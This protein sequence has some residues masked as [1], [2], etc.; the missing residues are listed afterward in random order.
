[1]L[2]GGMGR[3][4]RPETGKVARQGKARHLGATSSISAEGS[5]FDSLIDGLAV[6]L[7][8]VGNVQVDKSRSVSLGVFPGNT[9]KDWIFPRNTGLR[10]G[11]AGNMLKSEIDGQGNGSATL[12]DE[13]PI[14]NPI[15][16]LAEKSD[17]LAG[18]ATDADCIAAADEDVVTFLNLWNGETAVNDADKTQREATDTAYVTVFVKRL[19]TMRASMGANYIGL[20]KS[21]SGVTR[22]EL[23]KFLN[24]LDKWRDAHKAE[25]MPWAMPEMP[26][27][28]YGKGG[29]RKWYTEITESALTKLVKAHSKLVKSV[30]TSDETQMAYYSALVEQL[31]KRRTA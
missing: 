13:Q 27:T 7:D 9:P 12:L 2:L 26:K 16:E 14:E 30:Y 25:S 8:S 18:L 31:Q 24:A 3:T 15:D 29:L 1:M 28:Y 19:A 6:Y 17:E 10:P 4:A 23:V 5:I 22:G 11:K 21:K 20:L